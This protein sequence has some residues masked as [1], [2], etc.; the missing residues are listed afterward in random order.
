MLIRRSSIPASSQ[1]ISMV[2]RCPQPGC[3]TVMNRFQ[4]T[5]ENFLDS[6]LRDLCIPSHCKTDE[7]GQEPKGKVKPQREAICPL[8]TSSRKSPG[9][10]IVCSVDL[11]RKG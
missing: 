1:P 3:S 10:D 2:L 6:L 11:V 4:C 8:F 5:T 9:S 7:D